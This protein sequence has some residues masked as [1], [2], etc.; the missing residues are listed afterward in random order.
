MGYKRWENAVGKYGPDV[1]YV[2]ASLIW[3]I[4][5]YDFD[6]SQHRFKTRI[7]AFGDN[8]R[9]IYCRLVE[10][11]Q[12]HGRPITLQGSRAL[13]C[14]AGQRHERRRRPQ[15]GLREGEPIGEA[16]G[17]SVDCYPCPNEWVSTAGPGSANSVGASCG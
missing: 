15:P 9:D 17:G 2:Q 13:D 1:E 8:V 14:H 16:A 4:K 12:L 10:E 5:L 7:V 11:N 6:Q 3:G